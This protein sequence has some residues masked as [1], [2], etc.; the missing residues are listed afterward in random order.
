MKAR[1]FFKLYTE[2]SKFT[3]ACTPATSYV[4]LAGM[5]NK[6]T[7]LVWV[8]KCFPGW[9]LPRSLYA[10]AVEVFHLD[11]FN[12]PLFIAYTEITSPAFKATE[13]QQEFYLPLTASEWISPFMLALEAVVTLKQEV[14]QAWKTLLCAS[15]MSCDGPNSEEKLPCSRFQQELCPEIRSL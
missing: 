2:L 10:V 6:N 7:F 9:H 12:S 14:D 11:D 8:S 13:I 5:N 3:Q 1:W 4:L 15:P